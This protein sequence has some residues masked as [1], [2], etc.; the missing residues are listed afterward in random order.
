MVELIDAHAGHE[1]LF[2]LACDATGAVISVLDLAHGSRGMVPV[3]NRELVP[4]NILVHNHPSGRILPSDADVQAAA[5]LTDQGIGSWIVDNKVERLFVITEAWVEPPRTPLDLA[6]CAQ[7]LGSSGPL[8][9]L[10]PSYAPRPGQIQMLTHVARS[11]NEDLLLAVEAGTG[12]GKSFAYLIPAMLWA[13]ANKERVV[14]STA[15]INL[16]QQLV[17][18]DIPAVAGFL[19][20]K[21]KSVLVKGRGNYLCKKRLLEAIHEDGLL[22][23]ADGQL[24]QIAD[25]AKE[26]KDGSRTDLSF[27]PEDATWSRINADADACPG[28]RCPLRDECFFFMARREAAS[29]HLVISNH[30]LLFADASMRSRGMGFE[31]TVVLPSF[32]RLIFDE[33]HTIEGAA[34]SFFSDELNRFTVM[35]Y[36]SL[37]QR[38]KKNQSFGLLPVL[39]AQG[40][41]SVPD[42]DAMISRIRDAMY[43]VDAAGMVL[44]DQESSLRLLAQEKE[45]FESLMSALSELQGSFMAM[46]ECLKDSIE[47]IDSDEPVPALQELDL[48]SKRILSLA[49]VCDT[50]RAYARN[51]EKVYY[52]ERL[53]TSGGEAAVQFIAS[54]LDVGPLLGDAVFKPYKTVIMTSATLRVKKSF[55]FFLR[56]IGLWTKAGE[57]PG[58]LREEDDWNADARAPWDPDFD[59]ASPGNPDE[60]AHDGLSIQALSGIDRALGTSDVSSPFD[61][62]HRVLFAV[63]DDGPDPSSPQYQSWFQDFVMATLLAS[64]G[65]GLVLFTSYD[66]LKK[67]FDHVGPGLESQGIS[68]Y[69]QGS[70]ERTKLLKRFNADVSS[71]LFATDSFWEGVDSPGDTL[72]LVIVAK[73][74]FRVPTEPLVLAR[75]ERIEARGGNPFI[76][77]SVPEAVMKLRQGFGRLMRRE[78]DFGVVILADKRVHTKFYG[79]SFTESLPPAHRLVA[80]SEAVVRSARRHLDHWRAKSGQ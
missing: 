41:L 62:E 42:A 31:S 45:R 57:D 38:K 13:L 73:L 14:V 27:I 39:E 74:P 25:W 65:H 37:L 20:L 75:S 53:R 54:P 5:R 18:K 44:L 23:E 77:I 43:R 6:T 36:L 4:G 12:V 24:G 58:L 50:F 80:G 1:V 61:Y 71:C 79:R 64:G 8:A 10:F 66:M 26:S 40:L 47:A 19:G 32:Q 22:L 67:T 46:G 9:R 69:R 3:I 52:I 7:I 72:Q 33:A 17:E 28:M 11:F 59:L 60:L 55:D 63:P 34:T 70:E 16:Q 49:S 21:I 68:C 56:R 29:A 51:P 76:E 2:V 48:L 15:T 35:K 78:D 30:H